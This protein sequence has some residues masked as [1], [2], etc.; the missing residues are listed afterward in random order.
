MKSLRILVVVHQS[1]VP[2]TSLE[3]YTAQQIDEW[4]TEYDVI[5]NLSSLGHEVQCLGVM[6]SLTELRA[7]ITDW[8]E[9]QPCVAPHPFGLQMLKRLSSAVAPLPAAKA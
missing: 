3:G 9:R 1:L 2:P 5:R 7:A 4:R 6:D 8:H